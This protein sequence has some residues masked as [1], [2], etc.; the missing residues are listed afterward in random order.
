M[1]QFSITS[2]AISQYL[3]F[4]S[5]GVLKIVGKVN[6]CH[7]FVLRA[8][9][10]IAIDFDVWLIWY[11]GETIA[12]LAI[13]R[14]FNGSSYVA[15]CETITSVTIYDSKRSVLG[16]KRCY[17]VAI[18]RPRKLFVYSND[19]NAS[20]DCPIN[21]IIGHFV[22]LIDAGLLNHRGIFRR[23]RHANCA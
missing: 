11:N 9:V 1:R 8:A 2:N 20:S 14:S 7:L 21:L 6:D 18:N 19:R 5:C 10:L 3:C 12:V 13:D 4:F 17:L 16:V 23:S 22:R 15:Q